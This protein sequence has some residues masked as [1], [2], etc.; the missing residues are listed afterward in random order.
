MITKKIIIKQKTKKQT[1]K[2]TRIKENAK[3]CLFFVCFVLKQTKNKQTKTKTK[4]K[5]KRR[6]KI[7]TLY[8]VVVK[9]RYA[10]FE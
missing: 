7:S 8:F 5:Q 2:Q 9:T 6:I 3:Q 1:N 10:D 4:T